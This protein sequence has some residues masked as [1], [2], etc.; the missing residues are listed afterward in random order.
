[1]T[2]QAPQAP[3]TA[4]ASTASSMP[5]AL[6]PLDGADVDEGADEADD[7]RA[8]GRH[9]GARRRDGHEARQDAVV[10][11]ARVDV[12]LLDEADGRRAEAARRRAERRRH[13]DVRRRLG[14]AVDVERHRTGPRTG[15]GHRGSRRW[16]GARFP[17]ASRR[18][19][20]I[21]THP[22]DED[23]EGLCTNQSVSRVHR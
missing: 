13:G 4:K 10:D 6:T 17:M 21:P 12:L 20:S 22:E 16:R 2:P 18:I 9:D 23:A 14:V 3:W 19:E 11:V 8:E 1:M 7:D 15:M 5:A